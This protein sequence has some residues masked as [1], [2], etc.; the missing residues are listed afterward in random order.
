MNTTGEVALSQMV[1]EQMHQTDCWSKLIAKAVNSRR[2]NICTLDQ[3]QISQLC[4]QN[5]NPGLGMQPSFQSAWLACRKPCTGPPARYKCMI[6][7]ACN[8]SIQEMETGEAVQR[9]CKEEDIWLNGYF[10]GASG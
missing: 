3:A 4:S 7:Y 5:D 6:K 8:S 10:L 9:Y 1:S 2:K